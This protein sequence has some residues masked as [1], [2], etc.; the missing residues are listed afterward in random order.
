[1]IRKR[2]LKPQ[3]SRATTCLVSLWRSQGA[4][5]TGGPDRWSR[6]VVATEL[7]LASR[8]ADRG[9]ARVGQPR[10]SI[11]KFRCAPYL[12]LL[13]SGGQFAESGEGVFRCREVAGVDLVGAVQPRGVEA[14]LGCPMDIP[15]MHGH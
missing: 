5:P 12:V 9:G 4:V 3:D 13:E 8:K 1:M 14:R 6:P 2:E 7:A 11:S 15:G 10:A